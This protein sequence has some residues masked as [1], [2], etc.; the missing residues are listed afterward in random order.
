M[1]TQLSKKEYVAGFF[2]FGIVA[3]IL[4]IR[5]SKAS[6]QQPRNKKNLIQSRS[7]TF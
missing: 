4:A 5:V 2:G 7:V 6:G 1:T 3:A